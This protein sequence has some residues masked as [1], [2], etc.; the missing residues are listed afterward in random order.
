MGRIE[1]DSETDRCVGFVLPLDQNGLPKGGSFLA[2]SFSAIEAMFQNNP[3]AKL[4]Y[5]YMVQPL[6]SNFPP[7]C[8]ACIGTD[9]KFNTMNVMQRWKYIVKECDERNI[10]VLSFGREV[11][12]RLMKSMEISS[13]FNAPPLDPLLTH[14][15][16][17]TLLDSVIIPDGW[18][19]WFYTTR[20]VISFVRDIVH[21]AVKLKSHL[22][23]P[24]IVLP[25]GNFFASSNHLHAL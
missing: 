15:P 4:A 25:M 13:S 3:I 10:V 22:L 19:D 18:A 17:T 6:C 20:N 2:V 7:F 16:C 5:I 8:L 1:Y 9:N 14:I 23:K 21:V 11:D 24:Q 12:R